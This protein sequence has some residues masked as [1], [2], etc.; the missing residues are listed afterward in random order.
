MRVGQ[1]EAGALGLVG[2]RADA[3]AV[4]RAAEVGEEEVILVA[5][6]QAGAGIISEAR[7][8]VGEVGD[9]GHVPGRLAFVLGV[10]ELLGVPRAAVALHATELVADAPAAVAALDEVR[11]PRPVAAV[12]VVVA[13]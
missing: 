6:R 1:L 12:G 5:I 3:A 8:A 7:G 4:G 2:E 11:P 9:A 13:G 10:P